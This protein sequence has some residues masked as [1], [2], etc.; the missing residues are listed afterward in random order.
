M[1]RRDGTGPANAG[2]MTGR[3]FGFCST[4]SS[5][6]SNI[7]FGMGLRH[8]CRRGLGRGR[9][10]NRGSGA[11]QAFGKTEK[12]LLQE[13]KSALQNRLQVIDKKLENL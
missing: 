12:Q 5:E 7:G 2:A 13:R 6:K 10:L 4:E 11:N 3:G 8:S 9:G 1:P